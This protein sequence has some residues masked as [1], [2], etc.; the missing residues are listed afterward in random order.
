MKKILSVA[1]AL[2][3]S[4]GMCIPCFA[5]IYG[6]NVYYVDCE[7]GND[8]ASGKSE[9]SAWKTLEKASSVTYYKGDKILFRAGT[10]YNGT[11]T[12]KGDGTAENPITVGAYGDTETLGLPVIRSDSENVTLFVINNVSFWTVENLE[13]TAPDGSGISIYANGGLSTNNITVQNCVFHDIS[14]KQYVTRY[15][16][17]LSSSGAVSRLNNITVKDC[18]IYDCGYGIAMSGITREWTPELFTTPEESYNHNYLIEGVTLN[19][20]LYDAIIIGSVYGMVIRNCA[21]LNTC[22]VDDHYTAPMW[23][24]HASNFVIE[25]CEIAGALNEKDGMAV[26][27]DGWTTDATYQYCYTHDNVRFVNNC[28][29][30]NYTCNDNCTVRY[31]LSVNDNKCGNNMAQLLTANCDYAEDEYSQCMTGFKFYNNTIINCSE[32]NLIGLEDAYIANNI[33][34]GEGIASCFRFGRKVIDSDG[35]KVI[36]KFDGTMTNNCFRNCA[37][38]TIAENSVICNPGFVGND[39]NDMNSYKLSSTSKLIGAGVK[40]ENC[41]ERDLYG[42]ALTDETNIGCYGGSGEVEA[43]NTGILE[44]FRAI[45]TTVFGFI[46]NF[47][48]SCNDMYWIF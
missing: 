6:G 38:P 45:V 35:N 10:V 7:T 33:F 31:C 42:N 43:A 16:I 34:V 46:Y 28:C 14:N 24:H 9:R 19:N 27:F 17:S 8:Y 23:S 30:D 2:I 1:L 5:D 15:P 13:F 25:N 26:D 44:N 18:N 22:L 47:I 36:R 29:Y 21:L 41:G 11:F 20:L 12:A 48:Y 39:E 3:L 37:I 40:I 4:I 32:F